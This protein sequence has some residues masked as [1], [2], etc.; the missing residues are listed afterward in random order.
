MRPFCDGTHKLMRF[1]APSGAEQGRER[2]ADRHL[3]DG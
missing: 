1:T 2:P 3:G